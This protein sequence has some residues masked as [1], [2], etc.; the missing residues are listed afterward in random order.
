MFTFLIEL[1]NCNCSLMGNFNRRPI[2]SLI[3]EAADCTSD[4]QH[5]EEVGGGIWALPML[6]SAVNP[7]PQALSP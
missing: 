6:V 7:K 4:M 5:F 2:Q 1:Y 3:I